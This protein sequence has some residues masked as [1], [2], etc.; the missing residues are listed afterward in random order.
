MEC[1]VHTF[2][3]KI[4]VVTTSLCLRFCSGTF[5]DEERTFLFKSGFKPGFGF[6]FLGS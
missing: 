1:F 3:V 2:Q 4:Y 5:V 6:G